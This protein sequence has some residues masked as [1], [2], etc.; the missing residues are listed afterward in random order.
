M[1][2]RFY[3]SLGL[4]LYLFSLL[5]FYKLL[6]LTRSAN[7][8]LWKMKAVARVQ[9]LDK[10]LCISALISLEKAWIYIFFSH[11]N[12]PLNDRTDRL[13]EPLLMQPVYGKD[14]SE[15]K[16][17]LLRWSDFKSWTWHSAFYI[18]NI[19]GK[20]MNPTNLPSVMGK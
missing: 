4:R 15:F 20:G 3:Q 2:S 19:L 6:P 11:N 18:V 10:T 13:V 12:L 16:P 9:I 7:Q 1:H 14:Y 17:A 5:T 8:L